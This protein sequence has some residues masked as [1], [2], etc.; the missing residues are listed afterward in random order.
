MNRF[1]KILVNVLC[2]GTFTFAFLFLPSVA[3]AQSPQS[4]C[5]KWSIVP[6]PDPG[7]SNSLL[8]VAAISNS[9]AGPWVTMQG[10]ME[11]IKRW[12]NIGMELPGA[13][14]PA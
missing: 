2:V 6:S 4:K 7:M 9:D 10:I 13:L 1:V 12:P 14:S 8:N 5:G 3:G 11:T